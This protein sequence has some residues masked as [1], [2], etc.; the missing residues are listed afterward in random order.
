MR[1]ERRN[2]IKC[3]LDV[4]VVSQQVRFRPVH[5]L[6]VLFNTYTRTHTQRERGR[7]K[8]GA[9]SAGSFIFLMALSLCLLR[10]SAAPAPQNTTQ[11]F[12]FFSFHFA[13]RCEPSLTLKLTHPENVK[14]VFGFCFVFFFFP[15]FLVTS[16]MT[17]WSQNFC[18]VSFRFLFWARALLISFGFFFAVFLGSCCCFRFFYTF[19][20][21]ARVH[22][23]A[24]AAAA[25]TLQ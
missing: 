16:S 13:L 8:F 5:I 19:V 24:A 18:V 10:F 12:L 17:S 20:F 6:C 25:A 3:E 22:C 23:P 9:S 1:I 2:R 7:D 4:D 11:S 15:F 14:S 21:I